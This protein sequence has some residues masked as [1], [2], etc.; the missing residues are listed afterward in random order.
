M[1]TLAA[2]ITLASLVVL[3]PASVQADEVNL[4][5]LDRE[6]N[7][8]TVSTGLEYGLVA[9]A[10][11]SRV[12]P[13]LDRVIVVTGEAT[14]PWAGLDLGEYRF[15]LGALVP[16]V[17]SRHWKLAARAAPIVRGID[18]DVA[19]MTDVGLDVAVVGGFYTP[20]WFIAGEG[21][22]D[23]ALTTHVTHS[24]GYRMNVYPD[25]EDGWY[26]NAGANLRT[27]LQGG[28]SIG[29]YDLSLRAGRVMDVNGEPPMIPWYGTLGLGTRW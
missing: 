27:G 14:V 16:I 6:P 22:V 17:G 9:G 26:A 25:A 28:V 3:V 12:L 19:R 1:K 23:L 18:T 8:A 10:A 20:T 13:F 21:G 11:Y 24:D 29:R 4:G 7:R 2:V 15:E 5:S